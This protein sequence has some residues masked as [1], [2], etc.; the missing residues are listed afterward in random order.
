MV[1]QTSGDSPA[2]ISMPEASLRLRFG[3]EQAHYPSHLIAGAK[4]ME[5]FGDLATELTVRYDGEKGLL[6]AYETTEFLAPLYAGDWIEARARLVSVGRTSRRFECEAYKVIAGSSDAGVG[7][8]FV[9]DEPL[10]VA[11]A[12]GTIVVTQGGGDGTP[13]HDGQ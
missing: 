5:V 13:H 10:L 1:K 3:H 9:L 7:T 4:V 12:V 2:D 11:R 6:R 8:V